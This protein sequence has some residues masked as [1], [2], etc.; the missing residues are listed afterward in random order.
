MNKR[1]LFLLFV[2]ATILALAPDAH[3]Q[4]RSELVSAGLNT[5]TYVTSMP[6]QDN[7][8]V[9]LE[10]GGIIKTVD[11][12][13]GT[14]SVWLDISSSVNT[15]AQGGLLGIAFDPSFASDGRFYLRY[16]QSDGSETLQRYTY[17]GS[18]FTNESLLNFVPDAIADTGAIGAH[19]GGWVGFGPDGYLYTTIG[20]ANSLS[21]DIRNRAQSLTATTPSDVAAN[22]QLFG[23]VVRIDVSGASGY[24]IPSTNPFGSEIYA[25]GL[26]NPWRASFDRATGDFWVGDVGQGSWEEI[27]RVTSAQLNGANFQWNFREG[28]HATPN[29]DP[30]N[31]AGTQIG[32]V[33][34]Y[35]HTAGVTDI[36]GKAV[37]GGY[38]YRGDVSALMGQYFF[39]DFVKGNVWS[40]DPANPSGTLFDWTP[41]FNATGGQLH[42]IVSFGEDSFGRLYVV[43]YH[44]E[45]YR[46]VPEPGSALLLI[47][48]LAMIIRRRQRH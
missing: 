4:V 43:D 1:F 32:P 15:N 19:V 3:S 25:L 37:T 11:A 20:D 18:G 12:T 36:T 31:P 28:T 13:T 23:K 33:Y 35:S 24:A 17:N 42:N 9:V 29:P 34:E 5:P 27:N 16:T 14:S 8:L 6:G 26:R 41:I 39:G 30:A 46:I 47:A 10:K 22:S 2:F 44:G 48:G 38:V 40:F 7:T 45:I 21:W